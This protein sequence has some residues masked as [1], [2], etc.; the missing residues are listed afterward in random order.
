MSSKEVD[1]IYPKMLDK[2]WW[3]L[4]GLYL[5][6]GHTCSKKIGFTI[7]NTQ[8]NTVG[9]KVIQLANNL[10]YSVS[11]EVSKN[12]CYQISVTDSAIYRF[13]KNNHIANS[14]KNLPDWV[15]TIDPIYQ[16]ELLLGY[17]AGDGYIDS[18]HGQI[19]INSINKDI[20][21]KLGLICERLELPYLI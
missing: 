14:V 19:R 11:K 8:R 18:N 2:D 7:A 13:L 15:L 16:K 20:I 5:A 3:W 21:Y 6:D 9:A 4:Y 17:I 12:G 10:G 1:E